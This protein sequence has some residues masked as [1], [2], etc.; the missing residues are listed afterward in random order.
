MSYYENIIKS[1]SAFPVEV[2]VQNNLKSP[3]NVHEHFHDCFELL[4]FLNGEAIQYLNNKKFKAKKE[5]LVLIKSGD[6]HSTICKKN[7]D[8]R[9]LVLK[10]MPSILDEG[11]IRIEGSKYLAAFLNYSGTSDIQNLPSKE[12]N[13][14]KSLLLNILSEYSKKDKAYEIR[15]K[16]YILQFVSLLVRYN[17]IKTPVENISAKES[18]RISQI[19]KTIEDNYYR[20][21]TL[22]DIAKELNMNYSYTSRYFKKLTGKNFKE[23]LDYIRVCE[24]ERQILEGKYFIYE[25]A[26]KC[27]FSSVQAFNRVYL[28]IRGCTPTKML[29][30]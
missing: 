27:G 18:I 16:G 13:E 3:V 7:E 9:I 30:K 19:V 1:D 15:I 5:D 23:Y 24:A 22:K 26:D 14:L 17:L 20:Q 11:Y 21:I 28:R 4:F 8:C 2:F 12:I 25:I 6:V 29:K 10:F